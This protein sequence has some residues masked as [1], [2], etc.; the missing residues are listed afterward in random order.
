ML[1]IL[2]GRL[3]MQ[4]RWL[5]MLKPSEHDTEQACTLHVSMLASL[6]SMSPIGAC[7]LYVSA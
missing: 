7:N 3:S 6:L 4:P 1:D 2:H 5:C